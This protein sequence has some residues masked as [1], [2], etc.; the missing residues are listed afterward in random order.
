[1]IE[2]ISSR[3]SPEVVHIVSILWPT[4]HIFSHKTNHSSG[5]QNHRN[6]D[7][8]FKLKR[9]PP[10][11]YEPLASPTTQIRLFELFSG[12]GRIKG[13]FTTVVLA[14]AQKTHEPISYCWQKYGKRQRTKQIPI[15]VDGTFLDVTESL[16]DVLSRIRLRGRDGPRTKWADAICINQKDETEKDHQLPLMGNIYQGGRQTLLWLG[17][18]NILTGLAFR[19]IRKWHQQATENQ[20]SSIDIDKNAVIYVPAVKYGML[21]RKYFTRGWVV[22]EIVLSGHV[23]V[24]CGGHT[25]VWDVLYQGKDTRRAQFAAA[26]NFGSDLVFHQI[27]YLRNKK[28]RTQSLVEVMVDLS[29]TQVTDARDKIYSVLGLVPK[30]LMLVPITPESGKDA[31]EVFKDFTERSLLAGNDLTVLPM[32]HGA[33]S[34]IR[35]QVALMG[36]EIQKQNFHTIAPPRKEVVVLSEQHKNPTPM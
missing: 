7:M 26:L 10:H 18:A 1:M 14:E 11:Q 16:H 2:C 30:Q 27:Q 35:R 25:V 31:D 32:S 19:Y 29:K 13:R 8:E 34:S 9:R 23:S 17:T 20:S 21:E 4:I 22:Q 36:L 24:L 12:R 33:I 5:H 3:D 6:G 28:T 15:F